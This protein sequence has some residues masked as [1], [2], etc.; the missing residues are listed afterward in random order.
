MAGSLQVVDL[1][2][3]RQKR[4]VIGECAQYAMKTGGP[5]AA[6]T[7]QTAARA[8]LQQNGVQRMNFSGF[9]VAMVGGQVVIRGRGCGR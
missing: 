4:E 3:Y 6:S 8:V 2:S 7:F 1:A 9:S 5:I